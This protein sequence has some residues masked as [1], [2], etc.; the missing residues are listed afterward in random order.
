MAE[1]CAPEGWRK[2]NFL[3]PVTFFTTSDTQTYDRSSG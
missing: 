2:E 1:H 3:F